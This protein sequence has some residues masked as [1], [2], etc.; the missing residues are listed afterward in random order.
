[1]HFA[2]TSTN[3][4][5]RAAN[6]GEPRKVDARVYHALAAADEVLFHG[7]GEVQPTRVQG[8]HLQIQRRTHT[9]TYTHKINKSF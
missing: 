4:A 1:M 9:Y 7:S 2:E 6:E 8:D 3:L 5:S